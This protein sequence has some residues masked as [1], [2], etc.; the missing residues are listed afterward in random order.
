MLSFDS[1]NLESIINECPTE[2]INVH[3]LIAVLIESAE[4]LSNFADTIARLLKNSALNL[5]NQVFGAHL[6]ELLNRL[7]KFSA[8]GSFN[9]PL[10]L[11]V[12]VA[13]G[14]INCDSS[15][16]FKMQVLSFVD[17]VER[18]SADFKL[19]AKIILVGLVVAG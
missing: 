8:G 5:G 12:L 3:L 11:S 18:M 15:L 7:I 13:A 14:Y 4:N 10:V 6:L 1:A 9:H 2:I 19:S 17:S 16:L